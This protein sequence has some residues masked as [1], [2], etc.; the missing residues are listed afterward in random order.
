MLQELG[1][2]SGGGEVATAEDA[3]MVEEVIDDIHAMLDREVY[4]TWVTSAIPD[5]VI[6]PLV[7]II[8]QRLAARFGLPDTRRAELAA[9]ASAAMGELRTQCQAEAN[10]APVRAV[11]Y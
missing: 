8:A 4:L 5:T 11:F 2:L 1:V 9:A 6:E 3:A 7:L 10:D